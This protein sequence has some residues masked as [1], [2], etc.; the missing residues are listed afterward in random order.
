MRRWL[1]EPSLHFL[2]G[3]FL[4]LVGYGYVRG[5]RIESP[6]EIQLTLD[7]LRQLESHFES[8][9]HRPPTS[10][11]LRSL[12]EKR[13]QEEVLYREAVAMGLD[14]DDTIVRRR[15]AQKM[16]FVAEDIAAAR[17]PTIAELETWYE[18]NAA[19]FALPDRVTLRHLYFSPDLRGEQ[20]RGDAEKALS[21]LANQP[22]Q[23]PFARS[24]G[25]P[26]MLQ[27]YY[28]DRS[29]ERL[30]K[31]LGSQFAQAVFALR[32]GSWQGPIESGYGWHLVFVESVVGGRIPSFEEVEPD[33]RSA[34]LAAQKEQAWREAYDAMRAKYT[35]RLPAPADMESASAVAAGRSEEVL[36]V[37]DGRFPREDVAVSDAAE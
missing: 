23:S 11:E 13:V 6:D 32:P 18:Q 25:D 15:M 27:D 4:L 14:K 16:R 31:D 20:A 22:G 34:W 17:E 2:L 10:G 21:K 5:D 36:T 26:F 30:A 9:W 12:V 1:R 35:V 29:A 19:I 24:L 8:Q 37:E 7:D 33:V 28:A 3:G